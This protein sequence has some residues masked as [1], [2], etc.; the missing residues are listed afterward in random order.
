MTKR[1]IV[2]VQVGSHPDRQCTL[3]MVEDRRC[4]VLNPALMGHVRTDCLYVV[5]QCIGHQEPTLTNSSLDQVSQTFLIFDKAASYLNDT[6]FDNADCFSEL[7]LE[8]LW[9]S[10]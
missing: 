10:L 1:T 9:K 6:I 7:G 5:T 2:L 8:G 3:D 4:S